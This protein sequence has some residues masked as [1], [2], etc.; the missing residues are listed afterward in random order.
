[1]FKTIGGVIK[2]LLFFLGLWKERDAAKAKK[3]AEIAKE[4]VNA[5]EE[6]D[7]RIQASR[8][9]AAVG[10]INRVR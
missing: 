7:K 6:T 9:N 3:K 1:M 8:L 4:I 10:S 5:F 2:V